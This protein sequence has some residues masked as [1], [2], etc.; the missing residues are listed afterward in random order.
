M[1]KF[2]DTTLPND[3]NLADLMHAKQIKSF[4]ENSRKSRQQTEVS[5]EF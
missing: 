2:E 5:N 3:R 4:D 1:N